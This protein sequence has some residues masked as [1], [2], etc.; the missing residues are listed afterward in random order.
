[1]HNHNDIHGVWA[2]G[3]VYDIRFVNI[4][5]GTAFGML[6]FHFLVHSRF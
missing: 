6:I 3:M 2:N 4:V 5:N 1:M